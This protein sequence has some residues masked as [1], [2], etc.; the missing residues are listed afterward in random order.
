[1]IVLDFT[2]IALFFL[3]CVAWKCFLQ[4][5]LERVRQHIDSE[6]K[7]PDFFFHCEA[8]VVEHTRCSPGH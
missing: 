3:A 7:K 4:H 5:N 8:Y 2:G 6:S 1:M